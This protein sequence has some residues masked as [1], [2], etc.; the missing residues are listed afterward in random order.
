MTIAQSI[1]D[2]CANLTD[3][4]LAADEIAIDRDQNWETET[5]VF[6]FS[7]DSKLSICGMNQTFSDVTPSSE[8]L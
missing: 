1:L 8:V 2:T 6:T 3:A 5:T 4:L 7:D